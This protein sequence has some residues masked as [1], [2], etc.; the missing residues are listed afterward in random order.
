MARDDVGL[1][2][3][4]H[5]EKACR[6][7]AMGALYR[8]DGYRPE[9]VSKNLVYALEAM[10]REAKYSGF[11]TITAWNDSPGQTRDKVV[12]A[13]HRAAETV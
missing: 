9:G 10:I 2:E 11:F 7:C 8:I 6:F 4:V 1:R 5:S 3:D 13:F 12:K